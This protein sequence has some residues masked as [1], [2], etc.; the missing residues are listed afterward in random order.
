MRKLRDKLIFIKLGGSLITKNKPYTVDLIKLR[1]IVKE[2][3]Q[4]KRKMKFKLLIGNG[5]GSFP[6][7]S[8][9]K[10]RTAE[11][12]INK[13]S[14]RGQTIVQDDA[15]RLN[16]IVVGE[17]IKAGVNAISIQPSAALMTKEGKIKSFYLEP[18]KSYLK[19][20]LV[21]VVYGDVVVDLSRGC[22]IVS[23]EKIFSYLAKK[24]KPNKII[25]MVK[26]EGVYDSEKRV[27]ARINKHNFRKIKGF[28]K[29]A[30]KIDVTGGML[31]K[32]KTAIKM[33]KGGF[34]V[35]I[36]G[37]KKGNLEKCLEGEGVGTAITKL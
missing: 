5:G 4:L 33:A 34:E 9:K 11:G 27:I 19:H 25:M 29:Q 22:S 10:F 17:L 32:V 12:F 18:I 14:K 8:A 30:D 36:I 6:H 3:H 16:R 35:N 7:V 31:H 2:I 24:L 37:S 15:S 13:K 1:Q 28:L 21:P 20:D 23:T 26:V